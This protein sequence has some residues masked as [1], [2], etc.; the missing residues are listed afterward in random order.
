MVSA[1]VL[2]SRAYFSPR[3]SGGALSEDIWQVVYGLTLGYYLEDRAQITASVVES[4][5]QDRPLA[6]YQRHGEVRLGI[7]YRFLGSLDA[8]GLIDRVRRLR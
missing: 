6:G 8:P 3:H 5:I 2:D 4:Q 7:S 1:K